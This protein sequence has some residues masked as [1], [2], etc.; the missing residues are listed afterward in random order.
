M[1][2]VVV[3]TERRGEIAITAMVAAEVLATSDLEDNHHRTEPGVAQPS[4]YSGASDS[5]A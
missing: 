3:D 4:V 5:E 1:T 2:D